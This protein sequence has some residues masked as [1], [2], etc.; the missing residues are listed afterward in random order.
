[1]PNKPS[2]KP[3]GPRV[4][5]VETKNLPRH[6]LYAL[7]QRDQD[8][9][10]AEA[11]E[12]R[13]AKHNINVKMVSLTSRLGRVEK[14]IAHL[15][16]LYQLSQMDPSRSKLSDKEMDDLLALKHEREELEKQLL[17]MGS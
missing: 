5:M 16:G 15:L 13:I 6:E 17:E 4:R 8:R 1:M 12:E 14:H 10:N 7:R 3:G 2:T 9:R 11:R